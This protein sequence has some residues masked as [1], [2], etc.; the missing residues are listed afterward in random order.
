MGG[1][2]DSPRDT[3]N[4]SSKVSIC[5]NL[6]G[7]HSTT[8]PVTKEPSAVPGSFTQAGCPTCSWLWSCPAQKAPPQGRLCA[9]GG[10]RQEFP[11][12]QP[13]PLLTAGLSPVAQASPQAGRTMQG[14]AASATTPPPHALLL[15]TTSSRFTRLLGPNELPGFHFPLKREKPCSPNSTPSGSYACLSLSGAV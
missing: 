15:R 9:K 11:G 2:R 1:A 7:Q 8:R 14:S 6:G 12:S 4:Y 5:Y 13:A 10:K 3:A